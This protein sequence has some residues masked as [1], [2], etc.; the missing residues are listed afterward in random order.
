MCP[1]Q[2][3][4]IN[5]SLIYEHLMEQKE[6]PD[7]CFMHKSGLIISGP[8]GNR[9]RVRIKLAK[10][11]TCLFCFHTLAASWQTNCCCLVW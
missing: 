4:S 7:L 11:S 9:N 5:K 1:T 10:P 6:S 8:G 3:G 2:K